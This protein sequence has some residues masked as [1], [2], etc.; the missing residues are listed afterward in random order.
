MRKYSI[1]VA[2]NQKINVPKRNMMFAVKQFTKFQSVKFGQVVNS[3]SAS[4]PCSGLKISET[5]FKLSHTLNFR[6]STYERYFH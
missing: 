5:T 6:A 3:W 2:T 4:G 1:Q